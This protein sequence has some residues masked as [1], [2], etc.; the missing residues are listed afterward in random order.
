[1]VKRIDMFRIYTPYTTVKFQS[2]S[3]HMLSESYKLT[4][5][6]CLV[7]QIYLPSQSQY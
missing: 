3:S 5:G 1:M 2:L 7:F 6:Q 4:I